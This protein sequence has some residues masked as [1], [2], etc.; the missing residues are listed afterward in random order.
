VILLF[1]EWGLGNGEIVAPFRVRNKR[2]AGGGAATI[3]T[4]VIEIP[5]QEF[6]F[7]TYFDRINRIYWIKNK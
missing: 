7:A 1:R 5:K 2:P 3:D 6:S 4:T